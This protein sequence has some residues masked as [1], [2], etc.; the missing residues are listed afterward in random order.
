MNPI[1]LEIFLDDKTLAGIRSAEGGVAGMEQFTKD[2]ITRLEAELAQLQKQYK[3]LRK[4]G[5]VSEKELADVQALKGVI[6]ELNKRIKELEVTKKTTGKTPI[7]DAE[8]AK[9]QTNTLQM[10]VSQLSRELPALATGPQMFILAI[11]NNLPMLADRIKQVRL[12]N[13]LLA[14]SGQKGTPVWRQLLSAA[15]SWQT[16]L[17]VGITLLVMYGKEIGEWVSGLFGAKKALDENIESLEEFQEKAG[18]GVSKLLATY[19]RLRAGWNDL[20]TSLKEREK[21]ILDNKKA[22]DELGVSI[23]TI[24]EAE[25]VFNNHKDEFIDALIT[26]AKAA[27]AFELASEQYKKGVEKMIAAEAMPEKGKWSIGKA[28]KGYTQWDYVTSSNPERADA[29]KKANEFFDKGDTMLYNSLTFSNEEAQALKDANVQSANT[30]IE[31]SVA[32]IEAVIAA[33]R[34][35]LKKITNKADY[36]KIEAEIKAEQKKLD[37]ITGGKKQPEN[38]KDYAT[39]LAEA[40]VRALQKLEEAEVAVMEEGYKKRRA[41]AQKEYNESID[42]MDKTEQA[43]L[44]KIAEARKKGIKVS[45]EEEAGVKSNAWQQRV[46]AMMAYSKKIYEIEREWRE[47]GQRA[48]I[49]YN[50]Q[51]GSYQEKRL[52][53]TQDYA[54]KIGKAET[55]GERATLMREREDDVKKLDFENFKAGINFADVFSNLDEQSTE[56]L[57]TLRD[58][59]RDYINGA[60]KDLKPSDLKDLQQA[61]TK[62]DY[63]LIDRK[64]IEELKRALSDYGKADEEVERAQKE[65]NAVMRGGS[66]I[67]GMYM[68]A[69]GKLVT[70]LLTQEQAEKNLS[71]AERKRQE[72][73]AKLAKSLDGVAGKMSSYARAADDVIN[74]L[75]GFGVSIDGN[76]KR[77]VEGFGQ[78][79]DGISGFAK[80]LLSMDIGGMI[81]GITNVLGGLVKTVGSLFGADWGGERSRK[82]YEEA[83]EK[84]E[85]YMAVLD[86]VISK[87]KELVASMSADDFANAN[88]SYDAA[89]KLLQKQGDYA[90]EMGKAYLNSGASKGFLGIGSSASEGTK[91]RENISSQAWEQARQALGGDFHKYGIGDGRMTGL[92]DLQYGQLV[93]LRDEA[94]G[95]WAELNEDTRNYLDQIIESEEAW[96]EVQKARKEALT[97]TDFDSFYD[98]YV[99]MIADMDTTNEDMA[100]NFGDYLRKQILGALI[101]GQYKDRIKALYDAWA[102]MAESDGSLSASE[103]DRLKTQYQQLVDEMM[104]QRE[105]MAGSFGWTSSATGTQ[106][107]QSGAFTAMSQE[108]GTKLEGLFTSLQD[109]A[110]GIRQ[111]V[112]DLKAGREADHELFLQIAQNTAYCQRLEEILEIMQNNNI[113]GTKVKV[114]G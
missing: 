94:S 110:S 84:Y 71:D 7:V 60:A 79:S 21:Y 25:N 51:Y 85:S 43:T 24:N 8:T 112:T 23:S 95:F 100:E 78:M 52:A 35:S 87:Q 59:L 36:Q 22:F 44:K 70:R 111:L 10:E 33:K 107:G 38:K 26:R 104:K 64:P 41:V 91:Q 34:E 12:Q 16:L 46:L 13:E 29:I 93:K 14:K 83:K 68:D 11:S 6:E 55:D 77:V 18:E 5:L 106:S 75:E 30:V 80:S 56:T 32:A 88:N 1:K 66:V 49:E 72:S 50:K 101:A 47:K 97:G 62:I 4:Q 99:S 61:L 69:T 67:T 65:L 90:R 27:A 74:M 9:R 113:N 54:I 63:K 105:Q 76:A 20:T 102:D 45:P 57:S 39:E 103:Q 3:D 53:I 114:I 31:G 15:G 81:S 92:F 17:M 19:N 73:R 109:H 98:N 2:V 82:R 42:E 48:W 108:Q 28:F 40:R 58:K 89:R 86:K 96:Q 37:A